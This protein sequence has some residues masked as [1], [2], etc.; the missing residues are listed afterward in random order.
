MIEETSFI[1]YDYKKIIIQSDEDY[2]YLDVLKCF[3]WQIDEDKKTND[4]VYVLKRFR[5]IV[6]KTELLRLENHLDVC[7]KEIVKLQKSV[8]TQ[9]RFAALIVAFFGTVFMTIS[10]FAVVATP[11]QVA[12]CV[13]FA[14]P[15]FIGW[16]LPYFVY[17]YYQKRRAQYIQ[18]FVE[19]KKSEIEKLCHKAIQLLH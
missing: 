7:R 5:K 11:P 18:C 2:Q 9:A 15:G 19:E 12:F 4:S 1:G 16:I 13:I 14:I 6:N 8:Y 3:G 17:R 10:T